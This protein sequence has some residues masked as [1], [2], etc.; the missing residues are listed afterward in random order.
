MEKLVSVLIPAYN[1]EHFIEKCLLSII[2]QSYRNIEILIAD[3][4]STDK[5]KTIINSFTDTRIKRFH[6]DKNIGN[7][8]TINN[9]LSKASGELIAFQDA[10][11][12]SDHHRIMK[13]VRFLNN[14][15]NIFLC[16]TQYF[17]IDGKSI[18]E[19]NNLPLQHKDILSYCIKIGS[20]PYCAASCMFRKQV[21]NEIGGFRIYFDRIGAADSDWYF[22]IC[23]KY[24]V[25]NL[26]QSL[27]YYKKNSQSFTNTISKNLTKLISHEIAFFLYLQRKKFGTD[28]IEGNC[29]EEMNAFIAEKLIKYH[30]DPSLI[31]NK[32]ATHYIEK[33]NFTLSLVNIFIGIAKRP[34]MKK[35]Y[36]ILKYCLWKKKELLKVKKKIFLG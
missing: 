28:S 17:Y 24:E 10:D 26:P 19:I 36:S 4:G 6:N 11:D 14:H 27:Y 8:K 33:K 1:C 23:E 16:G 7:L 12:W 9:L 5:T 13:Q 2:T 29:P 15:V 32:I 21:Y 3:D 30:N 22:R 34:L 35:N 31:Y 20:P 18:S 25:A